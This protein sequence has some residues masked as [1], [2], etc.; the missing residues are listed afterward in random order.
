MALHALRVVDYTDR[1]LLHIL[2]DKA[3]EEGWATSDE[4]QDSLAVNYPAEDGEIV[5]DAERIGYARRC[6]GAR[7]AYMVRVGFVERNDKRTHWR[8]S[9]VGK[10]LMSGELDGEFERTLRRLSPADRILVMREL[11]RG[12]R[13]AGAPAQTIIRREWANGS[14]RNG[15][16]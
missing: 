13:G 8:V 10:Q 11:G 5:T 2:N 3:N 7:Y 12:Y 16:G 1:E 6:I 14:Y 15:N 4:L 9:N